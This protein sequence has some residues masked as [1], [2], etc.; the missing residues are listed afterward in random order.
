[1]ILLLASAPPL[2]FTLPSTSHNHA[3]RRTQLRT[4]RFTSSLTTPVEP[5]TAPSTPR[6]WTTPICRSGTRGNPARSLSFSPFPPPPS[7]PQTLS[8]GLCPILTF[9]V[10][11]NQRPEKQKKPGGLKN[12]KNKG[13]SLTFPQLSPPAFGSFPSPSPPP[14]TKGLNN[15]GCMLCTKVR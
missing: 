15:N 3:H 1:M 7:A 14:P 10:L 8:R 13:V 9:S 4:A 6:W 5:F 12:G 11:T 2:L